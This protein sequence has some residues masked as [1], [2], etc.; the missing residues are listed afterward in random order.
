MNMIKNFSSN[1]RFSWIKQHQIAG[2]ILIALSIVS[3][4]VHAVD[5]EK[6]KQFRVSFSNETWSG[7][8]F[9]LDFTGTFTHTSSGRQ[10]T[11]FGFYAGNNTWKIY[12]MPDDVGEWTY[13]T[14]SSDVDLNAMVGS[15]NGIASS[16]KGKLVNN[17][18][19]WKY[20]N[21]DAVFPVTTSS[22][23]YFRTTE[24]ANGL[25]GFV[26]WSK[27]TMGATMIHFGQLF[28][29]DSTDP[30][31][32]GEGALPFY[33]SQQPSNFNFEMWDRQNRNFDYVRDQQMGQFLMFFSDSGQTP[34]LG[35]IPANADGSISALEERLFKY[36]IAR[37]GAYPVLIWDS[38][39][40]I[41]EY[42]SNVWIDNFAAWFQQNDPWKH[43]VGSRSGGG[44]GGKNPI[45]ADVYSDGL[46]EFPSFEN[47]VTTW[48]ARATPTLM[49]DR[50]REDLGRGAYNREK[51]RRS[52]W[53]AGLTGGTGLIV[54]G[55]DNAGYLSANYSADFKAA[56]EVGFAT[57]FLSTK[58]LDFAK[59][60][61][62]PAIVDNRLYNWSAASPGQ[63]I[64]VY[65]RNGNNGQVNVDLSGFP[66]SIIT[67]W[68]D[69]TNGKVKGTGSGVGGGL[70]LFASP[71][72]NSFGENDWVLYILVNNNITAPSAPKNFT[73]QVAK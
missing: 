28:Y 67:E 7:N 31:I 71:G 39:I 24:L 17:G 63:E 22:L 52:V 2:L 6:W 56:V 32:G 64:V 33:S 43:P 51:I 44:S 37:L 14:N 48:S 20:S 61:P 42:R 13:V 38:G 72:L 12:F 60:S 3:G 66:G 65:M 27:N 34:D 25:K 29:F 55:N 58:P 19:K 36:T 73:F 15:F 68:Y 4:S 40:D 11:Q 18:N 49:T 47:F 35:G 70:T 26:D 46:I 1:T 21:G 5:V 62:L 41:S 69:P 23:A 10:L 53:Q 45:T 30:V 16:L 57:S 8:P 59:L 9:D 50:F 54:S